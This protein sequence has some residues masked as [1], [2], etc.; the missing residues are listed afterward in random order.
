M[1]IASTGTAAR[2]KTNASAP[3]GRWMTLNMLLSFAAFERDI[4]A[5]RVRDKIAGAKRKGKFTGGT[6]VLGYEID[7]LTHKLVVVPEEAD[8]IRRIFTRFSETGSGQKVAK[9]INAAGVTTKSRTNR[10]GIFKLGKE[11]NANGIYR[12]LSNMVYLGETKH[13][14]KTY[15]GEH[16]AIISHHLWDRA[17][18]MLTH[19]GHQKR[20]KEEGVPA[21]LRGIIRCGC[22]DCSMFNVNTPRKGRVYRYYVC[23]KASKNGYD[24]CDVRSMS[25]GEVELAVVDQLRSLFRTPEMIAETY[26]AARELQVDEIARLKMEKA[27][28]DVR[29]GKLQH[30]AVELSEKPGASSNELVE[31]KREMDVN[32]ARITQI[33]DAVLTVQSQSI[34]E[35]EVAE[36]L[37]TL[38]PIWEELFPAEQR[39][40]VQLLVEQV[41]LYPDQ[42]DIRYRTNGLHTLMAELNNTADTR[43]MR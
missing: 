37:R 9:E 39:R 28:L 4:I 42:I 33:D 16:E 32:L 5:E 43:S 8:T 22:C 3:D 36:A 31:I 1:I 21:L 29:L 2:L 20:K 6:P 41:T 13:H 18:A 38:D 34:D 27:E 19:D 35:Q 26:R 12:I 17:H 15:P 10:F 7:P 14:D 40:I 25:A 30:R 24:S 23:I 11:W